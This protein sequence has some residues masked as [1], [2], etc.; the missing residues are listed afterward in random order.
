MSGDREP[1]DADILGIEARQDRSGTWIDLT[2]E[3]D[4]SGTARFWAFVSEALAAA[5]RAITVDTS[6]LEF[7]DSAGLM[8]LVRARDAAADAGTAWRVTNPSPAVWFAAAL[9]G[10]QDL[11]AER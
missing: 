7:I 2:G 4:M 6:R 5:P 10:V 11:F 3:F 9:C 8:A 1:A